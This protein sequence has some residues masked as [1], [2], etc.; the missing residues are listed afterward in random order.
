MAVQD[1]DS[2][3]GVLRSLLVDTRELIRDEL[4]LMRAEVREE[5]MSARVATILLGGA[6]FA[7]L[8]GVA[9]LCVSLGNGLAYW[10]GWPV[11]AGY[12]IVSIVL[13]IGAYLAMTSG[14]KRLAQLGSLPKTRAT[15]KEN[16]TWIRSKSATK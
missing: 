7:A 3:A 9:L 2:I 1:S 8:L 14:R 6:I 12:G 5:L 10:L 13:L 4:D 16:L 11:W 15:M